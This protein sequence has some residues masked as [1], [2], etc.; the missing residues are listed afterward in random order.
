MSS[1]VRDRQD[2]ELVLGDRMNYP[3]LIGNQFLTIQK[4]LADGYTTELEVRDAILT[5]K[6]LVPKSWVDAEYQRELLSVS[7]KESVDERPEFCGRK[8]GPLPENVREITV[9]DYFGLLNAIV[10][11][12]D[13][14]GFITKVRLREIMDGSH[15]DSQKELAV[16]DP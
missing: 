15:F 9:Y 8:F 12:L 1:S 6:N 4:M 10:N 5:L 2:S 11:L 13:R 14:R 16:E 7:S 3:Y